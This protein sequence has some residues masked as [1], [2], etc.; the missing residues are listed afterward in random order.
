MNWNL[1]LQ[2]KY[3]FEKVNILPIPETD[4][5]WDIH[6]EDAKEE[7]MDLQA[8]LAAELNECKEQ[9]LQ[10]LPTRFH[11]Y[12]HDGT[13]NTPQLPKHVREDYLNWMQ[14][15]ERKFEAVLEA[16]HG[17]KEKTLAFLPTS[18]Q[19]VY[20]QSLHDA[21]IE[22]IERDDDLL[23]ITLNTA[24]GFTNKAIIELTFSGILAEHSEEPIEV[25]QWY[26]YD[27]MIK[28]RNGFA[29]RVIFESPETEWT[30]EAKEIT[31]DYLYRPKAYHDVAE[32]EDVKFNTFLEQLNPEFNYIFITPN[33]KSI[34]KGFTKEVPYL[35]LEDGE[36]GIEN[37]EVYALYSGEKISIAPSLDDCISF[38]YTN[39]YE[40]PYAQFHEPLPADELESAALGE[41]M[42]LHTRAWN[43]MYENPHEFADIINRVLMKVSF[44]EENEMIASV[45]V[46]H[47]KEC[48]VL[49][50]E[51]L[52][53]YQ[54]FVEE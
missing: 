39:V 3:A 40:D 6:M 30:I 16:A 21:V 45:L 31:A 20:E 28:T 35:E 24:S 25:G 33:F 36:L 47:F 26:I 41:D 17:N 15:E 22:R 18:V 43:T 53:K 1:S 2:A 14:G 9:L 32:E 4:E 10:V 38:I 52:H 27:E 29:L 5:D 48:G 44:S 37:G 54:Q 23:K 8:S 49:T 51:T 42:E 13:L 7:G 50:D 34:I 46:N 11:P 12:V 19:E